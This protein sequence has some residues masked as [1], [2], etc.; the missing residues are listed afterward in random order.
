MTVF[1]SSFDRGLD[2]IKVCLCPKKV[3]NICKYEN[4]LSLLMP[5][6]CRKHLIPY[7][8]EAMENIIEC[9]IAQ[10]VVNQVLIASFE[11]ILSFYCL[12]MLLPVS[13]RGIQVRHHPMI[14][15]FLGYCAHPASIVCV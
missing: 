9:L 7:S 14:I 15:S 11:I 13:E 2:I 8:H 5:C 3:K 12:L 4:L 10:M 1:M 6:F